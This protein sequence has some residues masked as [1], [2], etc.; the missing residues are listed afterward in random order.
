MTVKSFSRISSNSLYSN[1]I[2]LHNRFLISYEVSLYKESLNRFN[3]HFNVNSFILDYNKPS[4][5]LFPNR[6]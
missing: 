3:K 2:R 1:N 6:L 5:S 4:N